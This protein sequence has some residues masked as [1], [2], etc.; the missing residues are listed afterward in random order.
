MTRRVVLLTPGGDFAGDVLA[1]LQA[2]GAS[3]HAVVFYTGRVLRE[4]K[5]TAGLRRAATLPLLPV[6]WLG[7]RVKRRLRPRPAGA[8]R[9]VFTGPID[10]RGVRAA[11]RRLDPHVLVLARCSLVSPALLAAAREATVTVHPGL[12]PWIRGNQPL[13][14]A[15]LR[16]V[17]LGATAFRV[18]AGID[19][20]PLLARRLLSVDGEE[21][22]GELR[23]ALHRLW[24]EMT[25]DL[26][27]RAAAAPLPAGTPQGERFPLGRALAD[28]AQLAAV[29]VAVAR[30]DA[31]ALFDAWRPRCDPRDLSL[32]LDAD[33]EPVHRE[34]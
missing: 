12:L 32:P 11:L 24:V 15:L 10:G 31:K 1:E 29:Q 6:R 4:W 16:G 7:R 18:D 25:A 14:H 30:G 2:R 8:A 26:I 3:V 19:T 13:G 28:P 27:E 21:T 20:G 34:S 22:H 17:P 33:A 5:K 23:A 9:V